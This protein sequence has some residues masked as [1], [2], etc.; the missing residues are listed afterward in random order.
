MPKVGDRVYIHADDYHCG[1][2]GIIVGEQNS[3]GQYPVCIDGCSDG[4]ADAFPYE[5]EFDVLEV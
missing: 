1:E 3:F 4:Y 2:F 5:D